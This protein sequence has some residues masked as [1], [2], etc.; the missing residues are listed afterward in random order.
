M[1]IYLVLFVFVALFLL[2]KLFPTWEL[3]KVP[4]W[5]VR[6]ILINAAQLAITLIA[7]LTW[8]KWLSYSSL[9]ELEESVTPVAGGFISYF[10]SSF[11]FY[12]WHRLKHKN[13]M[14]WRLFHQVH[15]SPQ[16]IETFTTF[17]KHPAEMATN[18]MIASTLIYAI[19]G[20]GL[21]SAAFHSFLIA[22][23]QLYY[24]SNLPSP[25][26]MGYVIQRPEMHRLHHKYNTHKNNYGDLVWWDML[27][28]TYENPRDMNF[29]MGFDT[30]KENR[31]MDMIRFKDVNKS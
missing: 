7:G 21:E 22:I 13:D 2:E 17:Y 3:P 12:W 19:L 25:Y 6:T 16:R 4:T 23:V 1:Y 14:L 30:D 28:G 5:T 18:S 11:I 9:F 26:W 29:K 15:H 8:D 10:F 20:L 31:L 24:H 27:F